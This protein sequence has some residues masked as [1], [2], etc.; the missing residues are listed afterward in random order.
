MNEATVEIKQAFELV[1]ELLSQLESNVLNDLEIYEPE[2]Q[3]KTIKSEKTKEDY[4][5]CNYIITWYNENGN[6]IRKK[7]YNSAEDKCNGF[8]SISGKEISPS[9]YNKEECNDLNLKCVNVKELKENCKLTADSDEVIKNIYVNLNEVFK[10]GV[11]QSAKMIYEIRNGD[12]TTTKESIIITLK[13]LYEKRAGTNINYWIENDH[14]KNS[15]DILNE[16]N[17]ILIG[18]YYVVELLKIEEN[19]AVYVIKKGYYGKSK[20]KKNVEKPLYEIVTIVLATGDTVY[21]VKLL[22]VDNNGKLCTIEYQRN[23]YAINKESAKTMPDGKIIKVKKVIP[24]E[25][26][27]LPDYCEI[28]IKG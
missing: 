28:E 24:T 13:N 8:R 11:G 15:Y 23:I 16:S 21:N 17:Q 5:Y 26:G 9:C 14:I 10:L 3:D 7:D 20:S 19:E 18:D 6:L 2:K 27:I 22:S 25:Y 1:R 4:S 12:N